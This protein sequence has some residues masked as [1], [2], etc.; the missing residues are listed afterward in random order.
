VLG[1]KKYK[2]TSTIGEMPSCEHRIMKDRENAQLFG[3][4]WARATFS[5]VSNS[6]SKIGRGKRRRTF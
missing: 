2:K 1:L 4:R 6:F 3:C 5:S